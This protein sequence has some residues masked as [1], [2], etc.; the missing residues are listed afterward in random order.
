[1]PGQSL[2]GYL[3]EFEVPAEVGRVTTLRR[4]DVILWMEAKA[5]NIQTGKAARRNY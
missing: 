4:L 3:D 5:R 2:A 1:V